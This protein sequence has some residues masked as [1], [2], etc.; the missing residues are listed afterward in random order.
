MN[1]FFKN[2]RTIIDNTNINA[3]HF[4][5]EFSVHI[6]IAKRRFRPIFDKKKIKSCKVWKHYDINENEIIINGNLT[7]QSL[8][9]T[10][11]DIGF[12]LQ[13]IANTTKE[14]KVSRMISYHIIDNENNVESNQSNSL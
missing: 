1:I 5:F 13:R 2:R 4:K 3:I 12:W 8:S 6:D 9:Q 10:Y 14:S 7:K 11:Y